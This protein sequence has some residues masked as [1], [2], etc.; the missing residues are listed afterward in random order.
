ME[1][2]IILK[3]YKLYDQ[4]VLTGLRIWILVFF[5]IRSYAK[6]GSVCH[7]KIKFFRNPSL[8]SVPIRQQGLNSIFA[9][10]A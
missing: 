2:S 8:Y 4:E 10:R 9:C 3:R 5:W 6:V 7:A 1:K